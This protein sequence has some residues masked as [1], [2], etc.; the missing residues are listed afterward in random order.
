MKKPARTFFVTAAALVA[1]G[2]CDHRT[3]SDYT[4]DLAAVNTIRSAL[5]VAGETEGGSAAQVIDFKHDGG[6]AT[7]RG[8]F[9]LAGAAPAR[10]T[11]NDRIVK[12]PGVCKPGDRPVL[13][14]RLIVD[15][16]TRGIANVVV[17]LMT[18]K[19]RPIPVHESAAKPREGA[20]ATLDNKV[21]LF[22]PHVL[23]I[24]RGICTLKITNSDPAAHNANVAAIAGD[25]FNTLINPN[26]STNYAMKAEEPNPVPVTCTVHTWMKGYIF[27]RD[28]GY[29][30]VT[31]K[32]GRFEIP[33]LPTGD[34][35]TIAVWHE[36][37]GNRGAGGYLKDVKASDEKLKPAKQGFTLVMEKDKPI[38]VQFEVAASAF[39]PQ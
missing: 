23:A 10:P 18:E 13:S 31:D 25:T 1:T 24:H 33:N 39:P 21:C 4:P 26:D 17:Y 28:N 27:P 19:N 11:M 16:S 30:A 35:I 36:A 5:V 9:K 32:E 2:G 37:T 6:Y 20:Q 15:D 22:V 38:D 8:Q 12:D 7:L 14:E 34:K 29:F 3:H